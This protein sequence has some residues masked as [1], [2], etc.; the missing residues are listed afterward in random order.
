MD[1]DGMVI[2]PKRAVTLV[3]CWD[4]SIGVGQTESFPLED[5]L[6]FSL[7]HLSLIRVGVLIHTCHFRTITFN[8]DQV[9]SRST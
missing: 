9:F 4:Q 3:R 6:L 1:M 8:F 7:S 2:G 5:G